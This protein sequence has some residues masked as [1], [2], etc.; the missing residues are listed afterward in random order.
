MTSQN[1]SVDW[2]MVEM[3]TQKKP[4]VIPIEE[5]FSIYLRTFWPW[6][7]VSLVSNGPDLNATTA[8]ELNFPFKSK[9]ETDSVVIR[10]FV[11]DSFVF[12]PHSETNLK[13][14]MGLRV[15]DER[16]QQEDQLAQFDGKTVW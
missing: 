3:D 13:F 4:I 10:R 6:L 9:S 5:V 11:F 7:S 1:Q 2:N 8:K 12:H 15:T 16:L 14:K